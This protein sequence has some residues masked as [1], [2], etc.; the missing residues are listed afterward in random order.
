MS[1]ADALTKNEDNQKQKDQLK[2]EDNKK[3]STLSPFIVTLIFSQSV[4]L[5]QY[6]VLFVR[7]P[8]CLPV[9]VCLNDQAHL[10]DS[11]RG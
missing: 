2:S 1:Q 8:A 4:S 7:L 11:L 3:K 6:V 10:L 5:T 9:S